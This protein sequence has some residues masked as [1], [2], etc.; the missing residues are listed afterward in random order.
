MTRSRASLE[1]LFRFHAPVSDLVPPASIATE[2]PPKPRDQKKWG[3]AAVPAPLCYKQTR[4]CTRGYCDCWR[5]DSRSP[6]FGPPSAVNTVP[7]VRPSY[8]ARDSF[9]RLL[10]NVTYFA[11]ST[12]LLRFCSET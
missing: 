4:P 6:P 7:V 5:A 10:G 1:R 11:A 3:P 2:N 9:A 12:S 8:W